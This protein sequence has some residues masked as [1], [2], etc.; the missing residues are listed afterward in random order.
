MIGD[1]N[2]R[3]PHLEDSTISLNVD[4]VIKS[5]QEE[6]VKFVPTSP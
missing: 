3:V 5:I 6:A 2:V 4:A 1:I